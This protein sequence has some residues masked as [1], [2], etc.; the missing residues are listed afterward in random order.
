MSLDPNAVFQAC[1]VLVLAGVGASVWRSVVLLVRLEV[2]FTEHEKSNE[3]D[4]K[5]IDSDIRD[6]RERADAALYHVPGVPR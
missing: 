2:R 6:V 4:V 1:V 5:R 3:K